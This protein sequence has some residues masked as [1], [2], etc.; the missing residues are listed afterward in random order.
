MTNLRIARE[1]AGWSINDLASELGVHRNTVANWESGSTDI[2]ATDLFN[3]C[4][5]VGCSLDEI[6][7]GEAVATPYS[8]AMGRKLA[9]HRDELLG[10]SYGCLS[11]PRFVDAVVSAYRADKVSLSK[12]AE[13]LQMPV[14]WA[15][16]FVESYKGAGE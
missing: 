16:E 15:K 8:F 1:R 11:I 2:S 14:E 7:N 6:F 9:R 10:M 13:M 3:F 5:L 12:A 4:R